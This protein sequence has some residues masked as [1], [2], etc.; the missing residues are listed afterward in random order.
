MLQACNLH[1]KCI[2]LVDLFVLCEP[3]HLSDRLE[4]VGFGRSLAILLRLPGRPTLV[5]RADSDPRDTLA[6]TWTSNR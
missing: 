1:I 3:D 4:I 5:V 2:I 6:L